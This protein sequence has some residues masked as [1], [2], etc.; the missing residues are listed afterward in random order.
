L[1]DSSS[2]Y[3]PTGL[4]GDYQILQKKI[5]PGGSTL[6][7]QG[8]NS[9]ELYILNY[10]SLDVIVDMQ[11]V[12]TIDRRGSFFGELAAILNEPRNAT[13]R[14]K[15]ECNCI[16]IPT[17]F[18]EAV[19]TSRPQ[20]GLQL[21]KIL[22]RRLKATTTSL[23]DSRNQY[24]QLQNNYKALN[25]KLDQ[26]AEEKKKTVYDL[27][28]DLKVISEQNLEEARKHL[29]SQGGTEK[30][31]ITALIKLKAASMNDILEVVKVYK[32]YHSQV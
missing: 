10:G 22:A 6:F 26:K 24:L 15:E 21:I 2:T 3:H 17:K 1:T 18:V 29:E 4:T 25:K 31:L 11:V 32:K 20:I 8:D 9:Q 30:S 28:V 19:I 12:A 16:V 13:L 5:Y 23:S 14:A 27:M 7:S